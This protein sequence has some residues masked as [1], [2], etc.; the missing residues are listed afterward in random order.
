MAESKKTKPKASAADSIVINE[1]TVAQ[2]ERGNQNIQKW[3]QALKSAENILMPQRRDLYNNYQD[4]SID[5]HTDSMFQKRYRAVKTTPIEWTGLENDLIKENFASPWF[6]EFLSLIQSRVSHGTTL[7]EFMLG[8]DGL[9]SDVQMIPRQNVRPEKGII[10]IDG[11]S[12]EGIRY[13]EGMYQNFILQIGRNDDLGLMAK[14]VPYILMKRMN[15]ADFSRYNEMFGMPLRV[16]EYDANKPNARAEAEKS[17]KDYGSAAYIVIPKGS[18]SV[19]F[20]DSVKQSTAYAYDKFHQIMNDEITIGILGQLLTT[21]GADGGSLALGNVHKSVEAAINLEDR[22]TAEYII[23]YPFKKNILIPHG[24]PLTPEIKAKFKTSDEIA[25]EKKLDLWIKLY[26]SGAPIAE[27]DF[28]KEFGIEAPGSRPIV[29]NTKPAPAVDDPN[30]NPD[31]AGTDDPAAPEDKKP[32]P[33]TKPTGGADA[34]KSKL[35]LRLSELYKRKCERDKTPTRVSLSYQG[36]LTKIIDKITMQ[37]HNGTLK[38][39]DVDPELYDLIKDELFKGVEKGYGVKMTA[40]EGTEVGMLKALRTN[41]YRFSG[42]KTYQFVKEANSLLVDENN[43]VK[44]FN[45]F[46]EDVLKLNSSYNVEHLRTEYNHAVASSRMAGKWQKVKNTQGALPFLQY[47]TVGDERVRASH[48]ALDGIIKPVDDPFW[49]KYMPPNSWNCR[50]DVDQ[51]ADGEPTETD[52]DSLPQLSDTFAINTG[53]QAVVF[54][55]THPYFDVAPEDK[56]NADKNFG[57]TLPD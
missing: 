14:L 7:A 32:K 1:I 53:K 41:T 50:C 52:A 17:A 48:A 8:I 44:P 33:P 5:L 35:S 24:Y 49:D 3:M 29:A 21:G 10:S 28:Y 22:L 25:K 43:L 40:A 57:L 13:R 36:D 46:R 38:A 45:E 56:K 54:P 2:L 23:N 51:L 9:I 15:I 34:K 6:S 4:A 55:E 19:N 37:L 39:G 31:D 47:R 27:E 11:Y 12:D 16:Y 18:A 20:H 26:Q 42:A 30:N